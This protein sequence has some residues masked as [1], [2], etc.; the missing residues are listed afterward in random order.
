MKMTLDIA[1]DVLQAARHVAEREQRTLDEVISSIIR[2]A[3]SAEHPA[4]SNSDFAR[5]VRE[6]PSLPRRSGPIAALEV[7]NS[8]RDFQD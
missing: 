8:L 7:V 4:S 2:G 6:L 5:A 3:L 1:D